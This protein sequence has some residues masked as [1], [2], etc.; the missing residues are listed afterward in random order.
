VNNEEMRAGGR[1][2]YGGLGQGFGR[3]HR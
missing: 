3:P 2:P 1:D